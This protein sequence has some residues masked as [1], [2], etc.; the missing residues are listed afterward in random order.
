MRVLPSV[1]AN[2]IHSAPHDKG[3]A[4]SC[5]AVALQAHSCGTSL[6]TLNVNSKQA[7][8]YQVRINQGPHLQ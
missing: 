6:A 3:C 4:S 1:Y 2:M 7:D 8:I 5:T